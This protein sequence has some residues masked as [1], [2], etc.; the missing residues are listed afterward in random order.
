MDVGPA[1]WTFSTSG[2]LFTYFF[3]V[4][5][6]L[7]EQ[8]ELDGN[9]YVYSGPEASR[10]VAAWIN[11]K[12]NKRYQLSASGFFVLKLAHDVQL[13]VVDTSQRCPISTDIELTKRQHRLAEG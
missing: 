3:G 9:R 4:I 12:H 11:W 10:I 6:A 8:G 7:R 1:T 2:W 13:V 5:K